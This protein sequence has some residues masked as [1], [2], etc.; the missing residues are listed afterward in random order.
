MKFLLL[1]F[2]VFYSQDGYNRSA[3]T[4]DPRV[5]TDLFPNVDKL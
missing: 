3:L 4:H 5:K 2:S 1:Y